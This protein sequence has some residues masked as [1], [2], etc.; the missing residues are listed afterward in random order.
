MII[1]AIRYTEDP[2]RAPVTAESLLEVMLRGKS[3][4]I[5]PN[6][7]TISSILHLWSRSGLA[8]APARVET[9]FKT[10]KEWYTESGSEN[11]RPDERV[12]ATVISTWAKSGHPHAGRRAAELL[13]EMKDTPDLEPN[14]VVYSAVLD[15]L[16]K[17]GQADQARALLNEMLQLYAEGDTTVQPGV[18]S[19]SCVLA[20]YAKAGQ[21]EAAEGVLQEMEALY[22]Q[23]RDVKFRPN[24]ICYSILI[25]AFAGSGEPRRAEAILQRMMESPYDSVKPNLVSFNQVLHAWAKSGDFEAVERATAILDRI[26]LLHANGES[27]LKPDQKSY[28]NLLNCCAN[29]PNPRKYAPL[30]QQ[31]LE[32]MHTQHVVSLKPGKVSYN[33]VLRAWCK[34]GSPNQA[35]SLLRDVSRLYRVSKNSIIAP[36]VD[37]FITVIAG[38]AVSKDPQAP[39]RVEALLKMMEDLH[40]HEGLETKP[41]KI[42]YNAFMDCLSRSK[43]PSAPRRAETV[44]R[45]MQDQWRA[46]VEGMKPDTVS[47]TSVITAWSRSSDAVA[48]ERAEALFR[49]M[50]ESDD[51]DIQPNTMTYNS[52]MSTFSRF[53]RPFKVQT[54]KSLPRCVGRKYYKLSHL[55]LSSSLLLLHSL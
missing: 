35:E 13:Q 46:G 19:F 11:F 39:Q 50:K 53:N 22:E 48:P 26:E 18:Y 4:S 55:D 10:L 20:A 29:S 17:S 23:T 32:W 33:I 24:T 31:K 52:L 54:G 47:F 43:D 7:V 16:A 8:E 9:H 15:A 44:L 36:H 3:S 6:K 41:N 2:S 30:A 14:E 12:Y 40:H 27:P 25:G 34:A 49:E 38:W 28:N 21:A 5:R 42:A 45:R 1:D 51:R 37:L